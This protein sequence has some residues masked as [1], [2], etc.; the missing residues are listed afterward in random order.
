MQMRREKSLSGF[1]SGSTS[2]IGS[3]KGVPRVLEGV[4][5]GQSRGSVPLMALGRVYVSVVLLAS[6]P[7]GA[8]PIIITSSRHVVGQIPK[9]ARG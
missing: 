2:S 9:I 1:H 8:Y 3:E 4:E 7:S 5:A 6:L